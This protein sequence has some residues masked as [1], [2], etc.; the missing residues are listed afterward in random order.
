MNLTE[1]KTLID[2]IYERARDPDSVKIG[3][4]VERVGAIGGTPISPV[5][6]I[7]KGFDW[8]NNKLIITSEKLLREVDADEMSKL[9]KEAED[10]GWSLY[11][12]RNLKREIKKLREQLKQFDK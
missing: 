2:S 12:N 4:Q 7:F 9:R 1:L 10:L 8:D 3:I 11:E 6:R 5:L